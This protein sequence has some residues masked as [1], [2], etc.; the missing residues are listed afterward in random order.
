VAARD[1]SNRR[2]GNRPGHHQRVALMPYRRE[3][4]ACRPDSHRH[5]ERIGVVAEPVGEARGDGR[6][7]WRIWFPN[8]RLPNE[9]LIA[10][11]SNGLK[12]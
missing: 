8:T 5:Q 6:A 9:S 4:V 7:V 10:L 11:A 1:A 3:E 2:T 12:D